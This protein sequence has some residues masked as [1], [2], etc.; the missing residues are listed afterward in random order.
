M[1]VYKFIREH[2]GWNNFSMILIDTLQCENKLDAEKKERKYIEKLN[3]TLNKHMPCREE[4]TVAEYKHNWC[5]KNIER[6]H[7]AKKEYHQ[8][9]LI[10]IREK[11]KTYY[12]DNTEKCKAW[13]NGITLC[14]CGF[15]YTNANKARHEKSKR[16]TDT[17]IED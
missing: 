13:K 9:N 12:K 4:E 17:V 5:I 15:E 2:D 3:A 6:I 7:E 16:H 14:S 10:S 11:A 1:N 8:N